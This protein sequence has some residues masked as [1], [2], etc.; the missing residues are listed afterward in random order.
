MKL[1]L[2]GLLSGTQLSTITILLTMLISASARAQTTTIA[3][4]TDPRDAGDAQ[5]ASPLKSWFAPPRLPMPVNNALIEADKNLNKEFVQA[6]R[7]SGCGTTGRESV[8][9]IFRMLD[10]TLMGRSQGFSNQYKRFSFKWSP[11]T[12]AIVHTHPNECDPKPS[13]TDARVA[14]YYHVPIFTITISGMFVYDPATKKTSKLLD[15]LDWLNTSRY[16]DTFDSWFHI[17][18]S[19]RPAVTR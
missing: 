12:V 7:L 4:A 8:V 1:Y 6:W 3:L 15:G 2:K 5:P 18:V 10:G 17:G 11:T 9:L 16:R 14:D 19:Q 13:P